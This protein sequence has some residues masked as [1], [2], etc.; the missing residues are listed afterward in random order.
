MKF[1]EPDC[2]EVFPFATYPVAANSSALFMV[3]SGTWRTLG[4]F[5]AGKF[6]DVHGDIEYG[7]RAIGQGLFH[8]CTSVVSAE[9]YDRDF[10]TPYSDVALPSPMATGHGR[11]IAASA[12]ILEGLKG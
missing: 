3:R 2:L 6:P 5:D 7:T 11:S 1:S 8:L 12:S 9:L 10:G 4:G